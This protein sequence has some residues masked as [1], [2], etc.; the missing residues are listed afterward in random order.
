MTHLRRDPA[1]GAMLLVR[2]DEPEPAAKSEPE[3]VEL[4]ADVVKSS[5]DQQYLL[6]IAWEPGKD[7]RIAKGVDG[8]RD[9]MTAPDVEQ[10]A[11]RLIAK[12]AGGQSGLAHASFF[13]PSRDESH[14]RVVESYIYR[15][16]DWP[17]TAAD[18]SEVVVKAG[19]WLVG[20]ECDDVA[21]A[22]YKAG[23]IGGVSVQ[24][25][26]RRRRIEAQP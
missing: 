12:H 2:D 15:G 23:R 8:A 9:F 26:A 6:C 3:V 10:A 19:A 16:P 21:W 24:G 18:G 17:M 20:L 11:W 14:A 22:E 1:T 5:S 25:R 7:D 13:D 4:V